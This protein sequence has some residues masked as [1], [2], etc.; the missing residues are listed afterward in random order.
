MLKVIQSEQTRK[1]QQ[2]RKPQYKAAM[3]EGRCRVHTAE[4]KKKKKQ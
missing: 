4:K 1:K 3:Y 2:N